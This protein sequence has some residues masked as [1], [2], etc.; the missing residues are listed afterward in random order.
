[1]SNKMMYL[2]YILNVMFIVW[3]LGL[4]P[5]M[6]S[7]AETIK[8]VTEQSNSNESKEQILQK[9]YKRI[10]ERFGNLRTD[11]RLS[12]VSTD[13]NYD[14]TSYYYK[15]FNRHGCNLDIEDNV[16]ASHT[17]KYIES[18]ST[19][20]HTQDFYNNIVNI[21]M[22]KIQNVSVTHPGLDS[23]YPSI[24]SYNRDII[25]NCININFKALSNSRP[26][27]IKQIKHIHEYLNTEHHENN[28]YETDD[29]P[30]MVS[31]NLGMYSMCIS[32]EEIARRLVRAFNEYREICT[33]K[34]PAPVPPG[35]TSDPFFP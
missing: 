32:D 12:Y 22:S 21:N 24:F 11:L 7:C 28:K 15:L 3:I 33:E 30:Q 31:E 25:N 23:P 10:D 26:I 13:K 16:N 17:E 35:R 29:N 4:F 1:M 5:G 19:K 27:K 6:A 2:H 14:T 34:T 20:S 8:V 9:I 18:D